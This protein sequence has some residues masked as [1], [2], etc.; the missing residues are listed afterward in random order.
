MKKTFLFLFPLIF[1][2]ILSRAQT[3]DPKQQ[4]AIDSVIRHMV[5][6][7][8]DVTPE[9]IDTDGW[10][11]LDESIKNELSGAVDNLYNFK[12]ARAER[13]FR[14]LR[15]RYPEHPMPYFLMG[16]SQW[17]KIVPTNILSKQYDNAFF[18]YMDTTITYGEKLLVKKK[19]NYEAAFFLAAAHGFAARLHSE[20]KNW[21]KATVHSR[22]AL[23]FMNKAKEA[24]GL[25]PE[26]MFGEALYNY[27]AVW[28]G[29]N[30]PLLRPVLLF[31]PDGNKQ[32]GLTQLKQVADNGFYTGLEAKFFL[33]KILANEENNQMGAYPIS[34]F[35]ATKYPDNAYFQRF[36]ARLSFVIGNLSETERMSLQ[37]LDKLNRKMPGYE[38]ISGRYAAYFL[39]YIN[40]NRKNI[41]KAKE[42]YQQAITFAEQTDETKSGYAVHA[43]LNL[44]R[45]SHEENNIKQAK[46]YYEMV[47]DLADD[48]K[49]AEK[50]AKQY[51]KKYKRV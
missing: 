42:Y 26:F 2:A 31:F 51:L 20:R 7:S 50:E 24:N 33:M 4:A 21:R 16:L 47:K 46:Q 36:Y 38:S 11:L 3:T 28:I 45:M 6:D 8:V 30:Y 12:Y 40:Q 17:W 15:R 29:Q 48:D 18:A 37:I 5:I 10:L 25:S 13:Q 34:R 19:N 23:N 22:H 35:L 44:A 27:Y 14:S 41:P 49:R 39:G 43:Y 1:L 32:L 9:V